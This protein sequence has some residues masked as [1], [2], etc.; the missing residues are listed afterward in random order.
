MKIHDSTPRRIRGLGDVV[1]TLAQPVA[2]VID[3]VAKTNLQNCGGC[4][5]RRE[6]LNQKFPL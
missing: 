1:H 3:A 6:K 4:K 2:K 5:S